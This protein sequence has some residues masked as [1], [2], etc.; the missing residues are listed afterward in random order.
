MLFGAIAAV[1][2]GLHVA[3]YYVE[4]DAVIGTLGVVLSVAIPVLMFCVVYFVLYSI[5]FRSVD[6]LHLWLAAGMVAFLIAGVALAAVGVPLGWCLLVITLSPFV[7]VVGYE[8]AGY[9]HVEAD[10]EREARD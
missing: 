1:G 7:I 6:A 8:T 2:A 4:G 5:L 9:R 3:A 10:V